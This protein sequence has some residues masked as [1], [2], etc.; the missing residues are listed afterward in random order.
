MHQGALKTGK[1]NTESSF[2]LLSNDV[3]NA[4]SNYTL[5]FPA[6]VYPLPRVTNENHTQLQLPH[7][8]ASK[9]IKKFQH[10]HFHVKTYS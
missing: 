8:D 7:A 10:Y 4:A 5:R 9:E 1:R 3:K 2:F 6:A